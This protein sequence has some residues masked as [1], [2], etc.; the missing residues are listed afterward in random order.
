MLTLV[1]LFFCL[2]CVCVHVHA[3]VCVVVE[4]TTTV[5]ANQAI[6]ALTNQRREERVLGCLG[7]EIVEAR[8]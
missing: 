2:M 7:D 5:K 8:N 6:A 3:C 1:L 4:E